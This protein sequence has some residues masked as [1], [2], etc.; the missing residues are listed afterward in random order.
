MRWWHREGGQ[1]VTFASDAHDP[2]SLAHGFSEAREMAEAYGFRSGTH[3]ADL[4]RR[5]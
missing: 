3:P 1:A 2:V 4:W 5:R